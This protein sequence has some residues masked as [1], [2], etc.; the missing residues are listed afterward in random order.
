MFEIAHEKIKRTRRAE[1]KG[2]RAEKNGNGK[3]GKEKHLSGSN[4]IFGHTLSSDVFILRTKQTSLP[5]RFSPLQQHLI[6]FNFMPTKAARFVRPPADAV[7]GDSR[8]AGRLEKSGRD[9]GLEGERMEM[10]YNK[11]NRSIQ[12]VCD[13]GWHRADVFALFPASPPALLPGL[14]KRE[15]K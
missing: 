2:G 6:T 11:R 15:K 4:S 1:K 8:F 9:T 3:R 13:N 7:D 5:I 12:S 14:G 10:G